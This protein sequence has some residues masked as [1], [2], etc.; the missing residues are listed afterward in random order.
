M[1]RGCYPHCYSRS[2][3][4]AKIGNRFLMNSKTP[5]CQKRVGFRAA[6]GKPGCA[7][8]KA[9]HHNRCLSKRSGTLNGLSFELADVQAMVEAA[10][11][12]KLLVRPLLDDLSMIDHDHMVCI[13]N[14][15]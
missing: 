14:R 8:P 4:S 13:A 10:G 1:D 2:T 3:G 6:I 12:Q 11:L 15:A 5:H 7:S 9:A